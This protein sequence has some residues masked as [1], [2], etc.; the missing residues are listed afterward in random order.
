MH[1]LIFAELKKFADERLGATVWPELLR[2][3]GLPNRMYLPIQQYPDAEAVA[4]VKAA[5]DRTGLTPDALLQQF[6][7]FIAPHL[8]EM[9]APLV[10]RKWRTLEV[11]ENTE[12]T[13]H[14]VVRL[15]NPGATPP[16]L[17]TERT[18]PEEVVVIY[19][20]PRKMCGVARGIVR[21]LARHFGEMIAIDEPAC[22]HRG[23]PVCRISVRRL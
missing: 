15:R 4:V 19:A 8:L 7:E 18:G 23:A 21:G 2:Q 3:A 11:V 10:D 17:R 6:G 9:Y 5:C 13:I 1:G 22:M 12:E 14:Q 20:S 16:E